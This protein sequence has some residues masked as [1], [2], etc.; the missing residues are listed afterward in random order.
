[1]TNIIFIP[2]GGQGLHYKNTVYFSARKGMGIGVKEPL[3]S[4]ADETARRDKVTFLISS[5][6]LSLFSNLADRYLLLFHG[7]IFCRTGKKPEAEEIRKKYEEC[8]IR[9]LC[10]KE[11]QAFYSGALKKERIYI[12]FDTY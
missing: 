6:D 9:S 4:M 12:T 8:R 3:K 10:E 5:H 2:A 1:M 7:R 11:R